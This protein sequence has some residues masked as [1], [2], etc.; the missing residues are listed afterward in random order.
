MSIVN[1]LDHVNITTTSLKQSVE[2]YTMLGLRDGYRPQ[3]SF[4]GAWMYCGDR[5][6]VHLQCPNTNPYAG[7]P[8]DDSQ[9]PLEADPTSLILEEPGWSSNL[10]DTGGPLRIQEGL[11]NVSDS[12]SIE[13]SDWF[14]D[15]HSASSVIRV[16]QKERDNREKPTVD[17]I[18]FR[19]PGV[20]I[21]DV[22]IQF[23][24]ENIKYTY[25]N[26]PHSTLEQLFVIDPNNVRVELNFDE[27]TDKER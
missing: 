14:N 24:T 27:R 19:C 10:H 2:F 22:K 13:T 8:E 25:N 17:H 21:N 18:A 6:V 16:T 15:G 3:F 26:I 20:D 9:D 5:A 4:D 1:D 7:V 12:V 23:E 11:N